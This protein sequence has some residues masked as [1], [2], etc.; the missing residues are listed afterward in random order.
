VKK[1]TVYA[2]RHIKTGALLRMERTSNQG[3]DF[4]NDTSVKL[5][6]YGYENDDYDPDIWYI[7]EAC[8]AEY[9]RQFSTEWYNSSERTP[10][11][12]Y[13]PDE[14]G[15]VEIKREIRT[16]AKSFKVPTYLEFMKLQY[17]EKD[18]D[19]YNHIVK[20]YDNHGKFSKWNYSLWD[21]MMLIEE[22]KWKFEEASDE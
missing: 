21:L 22:G 18:P 16:T 10:Q 11:H 7:D 19:H 8:N 1:E 3:S 13:E 15:V 20:E 4:C 14:L 6:H 5:D 12:D 9:V 17:A 2:L